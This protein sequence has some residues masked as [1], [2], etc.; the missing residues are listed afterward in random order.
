MKVKSRHAATIVLFITAVM[1]ACGTEGDNGAQDALADADADAADVFAEDALDIPVDLPS[2]TL[3]DWP[4][5]VMADNPADDGPH[6]PVDIAADDGGTPDLSDAPCTDLSPDGPVAGNWDTYEQYASYGTNRAYE[7]PRLA[8]TAQIF[9]Y[10]NEERSKYYHDGIHAFEPATLAWSDTL[11]AAAQEYADLLASQ[12]GSPSPVGTLQPRLGGDT[13]WAGDYGGYLSAAGVEHLESWRNVNAMTSERH[14]WY[15]TGNS[16]WRAGFLR[17]DEC[18]G[19][20]YTSIGV[21][22]AELDVNQRWVVFAWQ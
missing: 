12:C 9:D 19:C 21:G 3:P 7:Y 17:F 6:D 15:S 4:V 8:T 10:Y 22:M 2:E 1:Q 20:G 16:T 11:A 18:E 5:D 13:F 14:L